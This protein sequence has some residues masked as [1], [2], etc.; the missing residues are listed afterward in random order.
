MIGSDT[1]EPPSEANPIEHLKEIAE[2]Q[3]EEPDLPGAGAGAAATVTILDI[4]HSDII[5]TGSETWSVDVLQSDSEFIDDRLQEVEDVAPSD[6]NLQEA[7]SVEVSLDPY[8]Y[9]R[10][11]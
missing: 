5:E 1:S 4:Q 6:M 8:K 7:A 11:I 3:D 9:L 10:R 2:I